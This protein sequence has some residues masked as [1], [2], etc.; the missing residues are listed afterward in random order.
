M[1]TL[2]SSLETTLLLQLK[3]SKDNVDYAIAVADEIYTLE[4]VGSIL[5]QICQEQI[6]TPDPTWTFNPWEDS[7]FDEF[8]CPLPWELNSHNRWKR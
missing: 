1:V 6:A 7:E 5:A 8:H 3:F 4:A 2:D